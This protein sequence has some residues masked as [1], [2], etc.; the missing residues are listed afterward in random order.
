[1]TAIRFVLGALIAAFAV[2]VALPAIALFDLV[3]GG[4]GLGLCPDGLGTCSTSPFAILELGLILVA[5]ATALGFA[6]AGCVRLLQRM[7]RSRVR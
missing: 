4:S 7:E 6:I 2:V 1:M 3:L 5:V